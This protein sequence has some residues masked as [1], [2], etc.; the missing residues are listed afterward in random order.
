MT[1][2]NTTSTSSDSLDWEFHN[3]VA[4]VDNHLVMGGPIDLYSRSYTP[5][6]PVWRVLKMGDYGW[7]RL[8]PETLNDRNSIVIFMRSLQAGHSIET[9]LG[10]TMKF[11]TV[12]ED[13]MRIYLLNSVDLL[14]CCEILFGGFTD[15]TLTK[16]VLLHGSY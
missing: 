3:L 8:Y 11:K 12:L 5:G 13:D 15:V 1:L 4:G 2:D 14:G 9:S 10:L 16:S 7:S 6:E